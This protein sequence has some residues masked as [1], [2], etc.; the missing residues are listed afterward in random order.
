MA[1][2]ALKNK[3]TALLKECNVEGMDKLNNYLEESGFFEAPASTKYHGSYPGGLLEHSINVY[4]CAVKKWQNPFWKEVMK[5]HNIHGKNIAIAALLHDVCKADA[6]E[7]AFKNQKVYVKDMTSEQL[8]AAKGGKILEDKEGQF[9]WIQVPYYTYNDN[10][11]LGH[12]EKSVIKIMEFIKIEPCE[13]YAIRWHMGFSEEKSNYVSV[14]K[15]M[16]MYPL[17][18]LIHEADLEASRIIEVQ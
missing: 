18:L 8:E 15:A 13:L 16:E 3:F 7:Q 12:G 11:P 2:I 10:Q 5:K 17:T 6:Y 9:A 14:G 1:N 4:D